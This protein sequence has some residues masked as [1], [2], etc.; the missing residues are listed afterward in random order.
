M[1]GVGPIGDAAGYG[2]APL[3]NMNGLAGRDSGAQMPS[4][5]QPGEQNSQA[6]T[7]SADATSLAASSTEIGMRSE[8]YFETYGASG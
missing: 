7:V 8:S 5:V 4:A 6:N 3:P 2:A 1:E